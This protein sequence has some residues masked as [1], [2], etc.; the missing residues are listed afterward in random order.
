MTTLQ[1]HAAVETVFGA[2]CFVLGAGYFAVHPD[3]RWR[4][5]TGEPEAVPLSPPPRVEIDF[6]VSEA[7]P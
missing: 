5:I 1:L 4:E 3:H 7:E 2:L 6:S